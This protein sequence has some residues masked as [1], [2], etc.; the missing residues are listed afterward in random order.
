ETL[1]AQA[2][3]EHDLTRREEDMLLMLCQGCSYA[4]IATELYLSPNTVKSHIRSLYRKMGVEERANLA[5]E[6]DT[7]AQRRGGETLG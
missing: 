1:C 7:L 2:A 5:R 6:V 4:E 3:K